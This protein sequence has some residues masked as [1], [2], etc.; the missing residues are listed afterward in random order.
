MN[1]PGAAK[2]QSLN[3]HGLAWLGFGYCPMYHIL[4]VYPSKTHSQDRPLQSCFSSSRTRGLTGTIFDAHPFLLPN[5]AYALFAASVWVVGALLLGQV[6]PEPWSQN[7]LLHG[8]SNIKGKGKNA[9][10]RV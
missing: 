9:R 8:L 4:S 10:I 6:L 5:L 3:L 1:D 7:E 2:I